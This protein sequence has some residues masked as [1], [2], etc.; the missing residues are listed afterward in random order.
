MTKPALTPTQNASGSW[1]ASFGAMRLIF[2]AGSL[3]EIGRAVRELM[4]GPCRTLL[5]TDPGVTAA[6]HV[7]RAIESLS[8]ESITCVVFD[9][10]EENPTTRHVEA[11]AEFARAQ[12][13][14]VIVGLGGG[15]AMDC[16]RGVNFLITN[17]GRMEDYK[18]SG[19]A[20]KPMLPSIGVPTTAGTGSEAQSF[21]VIEEEG[22]RRKMA[23]GDPKA[24]F[25]VAILD[26]DL[27]ATLPRG[28]AAVSGLDAVSHTVESFVSTRGNPVSR[29]LGREAWCHLSAGFG[30]ILADTGDEEARGRMLIGAHLAGA[31]V[32]AS[33]LGAAHACANPVTSRY[34]I[35][36]GAAVL[37]FLPHVIRFNE[38]IARSA[39]EELLAAAPQGHGCG[40]LDRL[41]E[42]MRDTG[43][44]PRRLRDAGVAAA[45]LPSLAADAADQWTVLFNPRAANRGDLQV[46]YEAAW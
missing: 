43:G 25:L 20:R 2:G 39:Y 8:A 18:G 11:G 34:G 23:C 38:P 22:S 45:D 12:G 33:M 36:H 24:R 30:R 19:L 16:A 21:A 46:L 17:G 31:A 13:I 26:P 35:A 10:V 28:V 27:T 41:I 5:V 44:L 9:G 3:R 32:E 1:E 40:S 4:P 37:L 7:K 6:G 15:S 29:M 42:R 14:D